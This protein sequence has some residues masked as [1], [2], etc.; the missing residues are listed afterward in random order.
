M[1]LSAPLFLLLGLLAG[2]SDS[3][4]LQVYQESLVNPA[5]SPQY[6]GDLNIGTAYVTLSPLSWDPADWVWKQ[7]H[8]SGAV[9]EQL[10]AGDLSHSIKNG[11]DNTFRAEAY[12][13]ESQLRGELAES[14]VWEDDLTL[15]V[16]LRRG[17][18]FSAI[19][20]VMEEREMSADDVLFTY[21]YIN[22]APKRIATYFDHVDSVE[23]RDRYTV[24]F[25]FSQF[26]AEWPYRFG[27]GYYSAIIPREA[28]GVDLNDWRNVSGTG[29]FTLE[30][31][32]QSNS[33][34]YR[35]NPG[36]W[37]T[38]VLGGRE[39]RLPFVDSFTYRI[40]K[41]EATF[42]TALR[43]G[44]LDILEGIR[45]IAVDH[46]KE[47]T[48]ELQWMRSL[49]M[50]GNFV[51]LRVDREPFDDIRVRRAINLAVN[52]AESVEL[53]YGGHAEIMAYPQHPDF[54]D[55]YQ[56]WEEMPESVQELFSY[57]PEKAQALLAEAGL[58]EGFEFNIQLCSCSPQMMDLAPLL[59]R[60]LE[61]VGIRA[62]LKPLEYASF[63][64][65]MTSRNHESG[66]LMSSGHTNPTTT[67]RKSFMTGQTW[68]PSMFSDP[69]IDARIHDMLS[70]R[71][72]ARRIEIAREITREM[73][74]RAPYLWLP[75]GYGYSAWWP[76]VKNYNG[77]LR[78]GAVR[79]GPIYSRLWLDLELKEAMGFD[80]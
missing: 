47:T 37:D 55:Y 45:W 42:L 24:V 3:R 52:Q 2:C 21:E 75:T 23:A 62:N 58:E 26:N 11:G 70:E 50:G 25:R 41:D 1:R 9:R 36:Y 72:E 19:P 28:A 39:Y 18:M 69:E 74:D 46:L 53:F 22:S 66:Y 65:M 57:N 48:P 43:T 31:Y 60:Y 56:P 10:F 61:D 7:N 49:G 8:D 80:E 32:V 68:N 64:S 4:S 59:V 12:I 44:K 71:D 73:L 51:V 34:T 40:I 15:V 79:P 13:P 27:Y 67:L 33:Q 17:I 38:E 78:A 30:R 77:E 5:Q 16:H 76:W 14:W 35:R 54:G 20:G 63:L 6:G 29:P